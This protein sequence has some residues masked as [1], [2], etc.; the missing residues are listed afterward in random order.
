MPKLPFLLNYYVVPYRL[1]PFHTRT[2]D[3]NFQFLIHFQ[4]PGGRKSSDQ[5]RR[6]FCSTETP[7]E[8]SVLSRRRHT[9]RSAGEAVWS[10]GAVQDVKKRAGLTSRDTL[11]VTTY[12]LLKTTNKRPRKDGKMIVR[13]HCKKICVYLRKKIGRSVSQIC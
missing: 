5:R 8:T 2:T 4:F 1:T 13:I 12:Q 7:A 6:L 10:V 9:A 3:S 11:I